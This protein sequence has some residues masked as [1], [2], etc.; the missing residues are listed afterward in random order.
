MHRLMKY[1][2]PNAVAQT[3]ALEAVLTRAATRM[4][5]KGGSIE[6]L[7]ISKG[8]SGGGGL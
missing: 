5:R 8:T 4:I 7:L 6:L 2:L 3:Q 1:R